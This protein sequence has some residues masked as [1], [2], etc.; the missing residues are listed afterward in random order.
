MKNLAGS[1]SSSEG[2]TIFSVFRFL[3][4]GFSVSRWFFLT[5]SISKDNH[6]KF[7]KSKETKKKRNY[8]NSFDFFLIKVFFSMRIENSYSFYLIS[9]FI[10]PKVIVILN[11]YNLIIQKLIKNHNSSG[12]LIML[13]LFI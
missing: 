6:L 3:F 1:K 13:I 12:F 8:R 5:T 10:I 2:R 7:L 11:L 4:D 9:L